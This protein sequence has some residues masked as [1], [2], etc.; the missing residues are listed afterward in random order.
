MHSCFDD[1]DCDRKDDDEGSHVHTCKQNIVVNQR[2][3]EGERERVDDPLDLSFESGAGKRSTG[4][5][6]EFRFKRKRWSKRRQRRLTQ[7]A[8]S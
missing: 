2:E 8:H 4:P 6:L 3:R 1:E 5:Q 7:E